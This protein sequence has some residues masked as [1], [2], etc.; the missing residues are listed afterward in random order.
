MVLVKVSAVWG[1]LWW[2]V[3]LSVRIDEF[4]MRNDLCYVCVLLF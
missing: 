2:N 4:E 1:R 3:M